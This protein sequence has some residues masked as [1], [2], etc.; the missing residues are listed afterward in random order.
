MCQV[1]IC[2]ERHFL[3]APAMHFKVK[4][5]KYHLWSLSMWA[6][7]RWAV[8][9]SGQKSFR[10]S[11][12]IFWLRLFVCAAIASKCARG[13]GRGGTGRNWW[14][15]RQC[16]EDSKAGR[17]LLWVQKDWTCIVSWGNYLESLWLPRPLQQ[18]RGWWEQ[19]LQVEKASHW[20]FRQG[21]AAI[22]EYQRLQV[23]LR[24]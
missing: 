20:L 11:F 7:M 16:D 2:S 4:Q 10:W 9:P 21:A 5:W 22:I 23:R 3:Y 19:S 15:L 17:R 6:D 18:K 1:K 12:E 13:V 8:M 14:L 24:P